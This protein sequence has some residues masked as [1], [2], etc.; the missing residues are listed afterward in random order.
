MEKFIPKNNFTENNH[1]RLIEGFHM[2]PSL[3]PDR[4][5][6]LFFTRVVAAP[7]VTIMGSKI[8]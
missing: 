3:Y 2:N 1:F 7:L 6:F 4:S 5:H 8:L